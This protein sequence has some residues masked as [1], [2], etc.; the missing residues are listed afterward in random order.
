MYA[1]VLLLLARGLGLQLEVL[2]GAQPGLAQ[3]VL[4]IYIY[5]YIYI[6]MY[7]CTSTR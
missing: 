5:I 4:N 3:A 7:V 1:P 2:R 6:Y